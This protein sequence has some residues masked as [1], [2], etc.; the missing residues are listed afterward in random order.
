MLHSNKPYHTKGS[1]T[2]RPIRS[3]RRDASRRNKLCCLCSGIGPAS[4]LVFTDFIINHL[5][6][7]GAIDD[8]NSTLS[9]CAY[10]ATTERGTH[11][12]ATDFSLATVV[13]SLHRTVR[14]RTTCAFA[15]PWHSSSCTPLMLLNICGAVAPWVSDPCVEGNSYE[16][17][18]HCLTPLCVMFAMRTK[19]LR[20]WSEVAAPPAESNTLVR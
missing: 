1:T 15:T 13:R 2:R 20:N 14:C 12:I 7:S 17:V 5:S 3:G 19:I 4:I 18:G 16:S 8:Q 9:L 10:A 6:D 11:D